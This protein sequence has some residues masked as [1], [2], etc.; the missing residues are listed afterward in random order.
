MYASVHIFNEDIESKSESNYID[1]S[2]KDSD[3]VNKTIISNIYN[4]KY[5]DL[6]EDYSESG[7]RTNGI[8]II[9]KNANGDLIISD[10]AHDYDIYGNIG[11]NFTLCDEF[12]PGYWSFALE[13]NYNGQACW[14]GEQQE[15]P[16]SKDIWGSITENDLIEKTRKISK[17]INNYKEQIF[18][19]ENICDVDY[20][21]GTLRFNGNKS[22]VLQKLNILKNDTKYTNLYFTP[23]RDINKLSIISEDLWIN[24][25][26]FKNIENTDDI[27]NQPAHINLYINTLTTK[28]TNGFKCNK[29]GKIY[30]LQGKCLKKHLLSHYPNLIM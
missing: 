30:K 21:W 11:N 19:D 1:F 27:Y 25:N 13:H 5:G 15:E 12:P 17:W 22:I 3:K 24:T 9:D 7:F 14:H 26:Y 16:V 23:S 29:C 10:I 8:Y 20:T 4:P 2:K 6:V 18:I 28:T